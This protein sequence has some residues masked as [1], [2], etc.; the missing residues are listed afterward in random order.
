MVGVT[1]MG[2]WP[3]GRDPAEIEIATRVI[4]ADT[5]NGF[6]V[7]GKLTIHFAEPQTQADA[8]M[9]ADRCAQITATLLREAPGHDRVI[10]AE[11]Q[12]SGLLFARYPVDVARARARVRARQGYV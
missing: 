4:T 2:F 6:T 9:A 12:L 3:F 5:Q 7:R 11:T 8:D 10:G 1:K